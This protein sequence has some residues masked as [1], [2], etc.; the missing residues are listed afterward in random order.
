MIPLRLPLFAVVEGLDGVG[1]S[2]TARRVAEVLGA[3]HLATPEAELGEA[4]RLLEGAFERHANA[5]MLWYAAAVA[6]AS[7]RIRAHRLAG[8]AVIVDRYFLSTLAYAQLRA[9]TLELREV[10][11]SLE[12]PDVTVYLHAPRAMRAMRLEGRSINSAEDHRTIDAEVDARLD[13]TFR[14]LGRRRIA[15]DFRPVCATGSSD[16]VVRE[17]IDI[18]RGVSPLAST[19][20]PTLRASRRPGRTAR[21]AA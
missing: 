1:K 9:A 19:R 14:R 8:R 17:V 16:D 12:V 5:R 4:R 15:G 6:R 18:V 2:V 21:R 20:A 11:R 7:D 3:E 10:E 13:A